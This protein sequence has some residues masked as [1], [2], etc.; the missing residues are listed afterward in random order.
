MPCLVPLRPKCRPLRQY[1]CISST[2]QR[3]GLRFRHQ[4]HVRHGLDTVDRG[5][6]TTWGSDTPMT[7]P[8]TASCSAK[9]PTTDEA[10]SARGAHLGLRGR[11]RRS[12]GQARM[13]RLCLS[14]GGG[15]RDLMKVP[16]NVKVRPIDTPPAHTREN[17][18][19]ARY[20]TFIL[21]RSACAGRIFS[22]YRH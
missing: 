15:F 7:R 12:G 4:P 8:R 16:E 13:E 9:S 14:A 6:C 19:P 20:K 17:T 10:V 22:R 2:I 3:G 1:S 18:R 11:F 21:G 5:N